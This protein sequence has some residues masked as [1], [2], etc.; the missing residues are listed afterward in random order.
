[1]TLTLGALVLPALSGC[2]RDLRKEETTTLLNHQEE[3]REEAIAKA[4]ASLRAELGEQIEK[5]TSRV[6]E[7][8]RSNQTF[9]L[10]GQRSE[11]PDIVKEHAQ[12]R[13]NEREEKSLANPSIF[14]LTGTAFDAGAKTRMQETILAPTVRIFS[15]SDAD[16]ANTSATGTVIGCFPA[17]ARGNEGPTALI[18]TARHVIRTIQSD[19]SKIYISA[20]A[21]ERLSLEA[22]EIRRDVRADL[23]LLA[24]NLPSSVSPQSLACASIAPPSLADK[25]EELDAIAVCGAPGG[26]GPLITFGTIE[27]LRDTKS[28]IDRVITSADAAFG[29]SGGGAYC[30][31][32]RGKGWLYGVL[33]QVLTQARYET[34]DGPFKSQ[35][36]TIV[37]HVS[38]LSRYEAIAKVLEEAG[39]TITSSGQVH[40]ENEALFYALLRR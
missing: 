21:H 16:L 36:K 3:L 32:T 1:M 9:T 12:A 23:S 22:Y 29:N 38:F 10:E 14:L 11:K 39:L 28:R 25:V 17:P 4:T 27:R 6:K 13:P 24:V 15:D 26:F 2:G 40:I 5:L 19:K 8:E 37:P 31:D 20:N 35:Y 34:P 7:L 18:L 30:L 33:S